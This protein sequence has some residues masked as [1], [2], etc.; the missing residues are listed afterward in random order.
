MLE[1]F[2]KTI[3][4]G[5]CLSSIIGPISILCIKQTIANGYK[6]G[7]I[8]SF[9]ATTAETFYAAVIAFG[10]TFISDFLIAQQLYLHI[11]GGAF[12]FYLGVKIA[13]SKMPQAQSAELKKHNLLTNYLTMTF[14]TLSNPLTIILFLSVFVSFGVGIGE[15]EPILIV[16]AFFL[17]SVLAYALLIASIVFLKRKS[18]QK[19]LEIIHSASGFVIIGFALYA[20]L[21]IIL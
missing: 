3:F 8:A 12:L 13:F 18:S 6:A 19:A 10:L 7:F 11:F 5:F 17:G 15:V 14:L 2:L 9:G 1:Y 21:K 20:F 16:V 4:V